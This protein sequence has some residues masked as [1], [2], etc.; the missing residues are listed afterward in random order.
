MAWE[1]GRTGDAGLEARF[2]APS[3]PGSAAAQEP[4]GYLNTKF[5]RPGQ[6]P[7][8]SDLEW[9]HELYCFGHLFQ[10]AVARARTRPGADDGLLD[11]RPPGRRPRL[12]RVRPGRH[13][14][15]L[16]APRDRAGA[17]RSSA[18][19][20]RRATATSTRP[21]CSSSAAGTAPSPTSSSGRA[22]FQDDVPV[23]EATVLRGHAV[24][25]NYLAA[26]AVDVAV[27]T[28]DDELLDALRTPVGEH[29]RPPHLPDRRAGLAPP[30]RGVR[31]RLGAAAG[32]R[33]LRDL[34]RRR[35]GH[36]RAGGCCW[37]TATPRY[38]DLIERTLF[39]V[40]A[41]L[42]VARTGARSSTR[43]RCTSG[44]PG[45][46]AGRP[47]SP[48]PRASSSL[49]APW[50]EVSCCPPNVARTLASLAAYVAT[51]DDDGPAA[52]PVRARHGSAPRSPTAGRS[53]S[54]SRRDYPRRRRRSGCASR[55]TTTGPWTLTLRVPAWAAG[56]ATL[57]RRTA[58][59][60][61]GRARATS[62]RAPAFAR[63]RRG[64]A[65]PADGAP[66]HAPRPAHRR[67]ARLRRGRARSGG[68][69][70]WSRWTCRAAPTSSGVRLDPRAGVREVDGR[71]LVTV[72]TGPR[73]RTTPGRTRQPSRRTA[74]A[75]GSRCR[76][77][78][79]TTGRTGGRR[80][81]GC[82]CPVGAESPAGVTPACGLALALGPGTGAECAG[83]P[84]QQGRRRECVRR[85][86]SP[87]PRRHRPGRPRS[88]QRARRGPGGG[89]QP[90]RL[91]GLRGRLRHQ[92]REPAHAA[93]ATRCR[94]S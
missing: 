33:L 58:C 74:D 49:R 55:A 52:A 25:A 18:A 80:R 67:G 70:A 93:R 27:E 22:Y 57:R 1:I 30:G 86:G 62:T 28:D 7:R 12:R 94:A 3:W 6:A 4:D 63:G 91:E 83:G 40:V 87:S 16:R 26:G 78:P 14:G 89:G 9:G 32:P 56:G 50:F 61:A 81:C 90:D 68:A 54:T 84:H 29:R 59:S 20:H 36:V 71:V 47:T 43:T 17:R 53:R 77:S 11:D 13:R 42:A 35:L 92:P 41:D 64:R 5:G 82:G 66:V 10:A 37:P 85:S 15:R 75:A 69:G 23:R 76:W 8:W 51:A 44:V 38:A 60:P 72:A 46:G 34:R 19:R 88:R 48:A 65:V 24:R 45:D 2:R 31:R 21:R 39:N 79:T 73:R